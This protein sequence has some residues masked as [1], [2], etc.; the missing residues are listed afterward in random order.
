MPTPTEKPSNLSKAGAP[1]KTEDP[2]PQQDNTVQ[3][4]DS[5]APE[6]TAVEP[7]IQE[8]ASAECPSRN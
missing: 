3:E 7:A 1:E 6:D 4:A 8:M 5:Q 2:N